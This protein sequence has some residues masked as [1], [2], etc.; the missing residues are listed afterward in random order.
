M[1]H[2]KK[3][4]VGVRDPAELRTIQGR[5]SQLDPP[6]RHLTRNLPRRAAE[7]LDGGSL[8]WVIAG[9][10]L[11]RQRIVGIEPSV[12]HDGTPCAAILLDPDLVQVSARPVK[13]FQGWRYLSAPDAPPD[14]DAG[15]AEAALPPELAQQLR[16]LRLI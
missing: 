7:V 11:V 15:S 2:L 13:A 8:Y 9:M 6:L 10:M 16:E 14:L 12:R 1:V 3:L 5:R 4:A